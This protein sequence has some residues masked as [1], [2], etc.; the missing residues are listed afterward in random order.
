[1]IVDGAMFFS[2]VECAKAELAEELKLSGGQWICLLDTDK[3][4]RGIPEVCG[5]IAIVDYFIASIACR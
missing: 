1:M 4:P 2:I 3:R 5:E